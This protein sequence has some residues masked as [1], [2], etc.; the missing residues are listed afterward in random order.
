M[1]NHELLL[2]GHLMNM[3]LKEKLQE[4]LLGVRLAVL[5]EHRLDRARCLLELC[6][7]KFHQRLLDR[8]ASAVGG[9]IATF[10]STGN[11]VSST[12]LDLM[13]VSGYT[14]IAERLNMLRYLS[15]FQSVH[16]GQFFTTM[17]TTAVRK[18]LPESWGFLCPVHTPDGSPC[19]LLNHLAK[20]AVVVA[21]P[22][23]LRA[24]TTPSGL[25]Q[26]RNAMHSDPS[27]E[28]GG[29][30]AAKANS[31]GHITQLLSA[32]GMV[33]AG[34][35]MG[36]GQVSLDRLF[37]PVLLDGVV[38]G[39]LSPGLLQ[40]VVAQL[41]IL[42][43]LCGSAGPAPVG[44]AGLR[45]WSLDP[46]IE[47][48]CIPP[49]RVGSGAYPGLYLFTQP[50]RL[51]RPVLQLRSGLP[52]W[53]GPMEQVFL[54]IA[55]LSRDVQQH[56]THVELDP[57]AM[58][59]HIAA[60]T[61]YSDYN[62]S[63]RNMYQCQM[64]KQTMGTPVHSWQHRAD[65]KLYRIQN[66][67]AALVQ[68]RVHAAYLA[69]EY[70]QGTNAVVAVLSYTGYDM[71]DAMII[72][73]ASFE[74]GFGHGSMY[75]TIVVDLDEEEKQRSTP[76]ARPQLRFCNVA[77]SSGPSRPRTDSRQPGQDAYHSQLLKFCDALDYDGLP[78][79]GSSVGHGEPLVCLV[80]SLTG[81]HHYVAHKDHERAAVAAVR[82]V[83]L[84]VS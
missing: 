2:P 6:T 50:G 22:V 62:Q 29:W 27:G 68:T 37:V 1:M 52:E 9:K 75:K 19:G 34:V 31:R 8:A 20:D 53:V 40:E 10:L 48:A 4:V 44:L 55:C 45:R 71:E 41:R 81:T 42:K 76:E 60:L 36:D 83:R 49:A 35:S 64:G 54:E 11:I 15:H 73:K 18:L 16:R 84:A 26:P 46:T 32:L 24:P 69:D 28:D 38:L 56:S 80:D 72:S 57:A 77:D 51:V 59:S 25:I 39:G 79:A 66:P 47:L 61:P 23:S 14:V 7:P 17:K 13:Q 30:N 78:L 5:K 65:N 12:G 43:S 82:I 67:Q 21:Y 70:P 33:A 63:P 74:R 58:L 3:Y